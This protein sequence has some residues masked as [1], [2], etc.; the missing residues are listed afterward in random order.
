MAMT[1]MQRSWL[2]ALT[3]IADLKAASAP[4]GGGDAPPPPATETDLFF[5]KDSAELTPS[6]VAALDAYAQADAKAGGA[7][8]ITVAGYASLD[9]DAGHNRKLAGKRAQAVVDHLVGQGIAKDR[10]SGAGKG[11]TEQFGKGDA[12]GNRRATIAPKPPAAAAPAPPVQ[13]APVAPPALKPLS[14]EQLDAIVNKK[15]GVARSQVQSELTDFLTALQKAQ[16]G[17]SVRVTDKVRMAGDRLTAGLGDANL[18]V[19]ALLH[20]DTFNFVP[21]ELAAKIAKA[22]PDFIPQANFQAFLKLKPVD[23]AGSKPVSVAG[24]IAR[25]ITPEIKKAIGFLPKAVQDKIVDG[26]EDA[27]AKGIVGLAEKAIE[28]SG[29]DDATSKAV[30]GAV[31]AAI[32]QKDGEAQK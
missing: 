20:D 10:V 21:A 18:A 17:R 25:V 23:V 12:A 30:L 22:L 13:D 27:V 28:G 6:D 9:G 1:E 24:A 31:E 19:A 11:A 32:K 7:G 14:R 16:G 4:G 3:G 8:P 29:L 15:D 26:I 5:A 2:Q